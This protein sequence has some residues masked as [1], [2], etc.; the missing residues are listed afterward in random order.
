MCG[1][2]LDGLFVCSFVCL[3]VCL[4]A[5]LF[6]YLFAHFSAFSCE[7]EKTAAKFRS[8][9]DIVDICAN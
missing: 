2:A 8:I 1:N 4:F 7:P 3:F 5:C 9:Q 6:V